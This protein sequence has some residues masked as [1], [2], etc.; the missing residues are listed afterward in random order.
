M[1]EEADVETEGQPARRPRVKKGG[2]L[3]SKGALSFVNS[4]VTVPGLTFVTA[5]ARV[6]F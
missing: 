5:L 2:V 4:I 1:I 6:A 3:W